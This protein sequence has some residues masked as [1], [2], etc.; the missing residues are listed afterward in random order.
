MEL[1]ENILRKILSS[2]SVTRPY[3]KDVYSSD[4]IEMPMKFPASM[5]VNLDKDEGDG[6]HWVGIYNPSASDAYYFDSFGTMPKGDINQFIQ[7]FPDTKIPN[8]FPIQSIKSEVCGHYVVY[9]I[10]KCSQGHAYHNVL[11]DLGRKR[12]MDLYVYTFLRGLV[13]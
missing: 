1:D 2:C 13:K 4:N 9:F 11:T 8:P 5:V 6:Y 12:N 3:F 10:Y 7:N